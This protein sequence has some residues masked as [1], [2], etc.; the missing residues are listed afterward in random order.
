MCSLG[1]T[2]QHIVLRDTG[3]LVL[4]NLGQRRR[5]GNMNLG[6]EVAK[7]MVWNTDGTRVAI[8]SSKVDVLKY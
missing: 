6:V 3:Y 7:R 8:F 1:L 4:Y 2:D 5:L